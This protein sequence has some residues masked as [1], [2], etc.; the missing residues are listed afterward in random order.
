M[1]I[2]AICGMFVLIVAMVLVI[3]EDYSNGKDTEFFDD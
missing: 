3:S 1:K 2:I